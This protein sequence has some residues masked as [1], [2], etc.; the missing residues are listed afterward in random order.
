MKC[1]FCNQEMEVGFLESSHKFYFTSKAH[2]ILTLPHLRD[3]DVELSGSF[4]PRHEAFI[5]RSCK[6]I[7]IDYALDEQEEAEG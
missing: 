2:Y 3:G 5:C 1:P 4:F 6:K 7:I